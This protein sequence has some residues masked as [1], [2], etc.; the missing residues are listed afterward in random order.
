MIDF[1]VRKGDKQR[2][3]EC[4]VLRLHGIHCFDFGQL[5]LQ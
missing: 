4:R 2:V 5:V 3:R 1:E